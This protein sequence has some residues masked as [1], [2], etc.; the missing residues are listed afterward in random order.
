MFTSYP[1]RARRVTAE[2]SRCCF[3]VVIDLSFTSFGTS[4][5]SEIFPFL[6][7]VHNPFLMVLVKYASVFLEGRSITHALHYQKPFLKNKCNGR[8]TQCNWGLA[9]ICLKN[10]TKRIN[11]HGLSLVIVTAILLKRTQCG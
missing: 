3:F 6:E 1:E 11:S 9:L 8:K 10:E 4:A 5:Q 7:A 2:S